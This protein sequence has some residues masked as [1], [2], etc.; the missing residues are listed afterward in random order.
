MS[1]RKSPSNNALMPTMS[2]ESHFHHTRVV[3]IE[4]SHPGNIGASARAMATMGFSDLR[5][6]N[7]AFFPHTKAT[8]M[9]VGASHLLDSAKIHAELPSAIAGCA[10]VLGLTARARDHMPPVLSVREAMEEWK[11][12]SKHAPTA[13]VFGRERNGLENEDLWQCHRLVTI[14]VNPDFSSL[15]LA[16]AVQLICYEAR[17]MALGDEV[18]KKFI[19]TEERATSDDIQHLIAHFENTMRQVGFYRDDHPQPL[20]AKLRTMFHRLVMERQDVRVLRGFLHKVDKALLNSKT[21]LH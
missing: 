19:H 4:T 2:G 3:L 10:L 21:P 14:P 11:A 7:P 12:V 8:E 17:Q 15:N 20:H 6:V 9:A 5:L 13:F 1:F 16:S 18:N